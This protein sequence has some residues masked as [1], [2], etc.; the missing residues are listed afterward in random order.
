MRDALRRARGLALALLLMISFIGQA[1]GA[2]SA[3]LPSFNAGDLAIVFAFRDGSTT[4]PSLPAGWTN[5]LTRGTTTSC[6]QRV[7]Y[8][9]LVSGDTTTGTWTNATSV[10]VLV[11]RSSVAAVV[12]G[13]S[14]SNGGT[15]N[16]VNF[17]ALTMQI[18]DGS[19]WVAG[20]I[21]H[22]STDTTIET[23]PAGMTNRANVQDATDEASGHDTNGGVAAWSST[24]QTITG[25]ASG[26]QSATVE[27][28]EAVLH[29][30]TVFTDGSGGG[31]NPAAT[32]GAGRAG[33]AIVAVANWNDNTTTL[34]SVTDDAGNTYVAAGPA[35]SNGTHTCRAYVAQN[36]TA[37]ATAVTYHFSANSF[38]GFIELYVSEYVGVDATA[39]V[40]QHS[41]AFGTSAVP[42][43][44]AKTTTTAKELIYG[45]GSGAS[46]VTNGGTYTSRDASNGNRVEDKLVSSI[47]SYSADFTMTSGTWIA[48]MVTLRQAGQAA[49]SLLFPSNPMAALLLR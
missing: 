30:Q 2:A 17:P 27:V 37:G 43:S 14:A 26:W 7:G 36:A 5:I 21:G 3:T 40:D 25:T 49:K 28:R 35:V 29:A 19:S 34:D 10:V 12:P 20:F 38:G 16:T 18:A 8:R 31:Q 47:G 46:S 48:I 41:E 15:T 33:S 13:A 32:M 42:D 23:A 1:T 45:F 44:G 6:S 9:Q 4:A 11:Y 24:N 22:R 39:A